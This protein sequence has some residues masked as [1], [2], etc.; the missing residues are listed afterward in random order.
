M[1]HGSFFGGYALKSIQ[2]ELVRLGLVSNDESEKATKRLH[3]LATIRRFVQST[4]VL[5][6]AKLILMFSSMRSFMEKAKRWLQI[7]SSPEWVAVLKELATKVA[8][9]CTCDSQ[10]LAEAKIFFDELDSGL[11]NRPSEE[12]GHY[13]NQMFEK[14]KPDW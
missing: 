10:R 3:S 8:D 1:F 13:L 12:H 9:S 5:D 11:K 7:D 14:F 6:K 2:S 4:G